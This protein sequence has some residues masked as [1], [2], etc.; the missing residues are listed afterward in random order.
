MEVTRTHPIPESRAIT[1]ADAIAA[2]TPDSRC[3]CPECCPRAG[4]RPLSLRPVV[5]EV[6]RSG[7]GDTYLTVRA[8]RYLAHTSLPH[9]EYGCRMFPLSPYAS[10]PCHGPA[11]PA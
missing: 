6:V 3:H 8:E 2:G 11:I 7:S 1:A 4:I 5:N 10:S 9:S